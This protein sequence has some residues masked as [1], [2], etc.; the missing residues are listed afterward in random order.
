MADTKGTGWITYAGIM[1][2]LSGVISIID[3]I[4]AFRYSDTVVSLVFFEDN[5]EVWGVLWLI[6]GAILIFAG[7]GVFRAQSWA[8]WVGVGAA[9]LAIVSN[10]S[11]AQIQPMQSLIG[12][13]LAALVLYG[14]L[15]HDTVDVT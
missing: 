5:L 7:F 13:V 15:A 2:I 10:L 9:S 3:A 6:V 4:W 14:L 1:L 11:W 12:V 8:Q